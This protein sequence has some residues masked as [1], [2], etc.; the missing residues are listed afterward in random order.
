MFPA[1]SNMIR[2]PIKKSCEQGIS[3]L[4]FLKLAKCIEFEPEK[5]HFPLY[6]EIFPG[7]G[8]Y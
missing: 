6:N 7:I 1:I 5:Q 3:F 4:S 2:D 8:V